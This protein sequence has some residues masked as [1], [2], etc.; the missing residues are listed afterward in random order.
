V[1]VDA[2]LKIGFTSS[3]IGKFGGGNYLRV[4]SEAVK[5]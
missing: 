4:F 5:K 2:M 1:V 3:E